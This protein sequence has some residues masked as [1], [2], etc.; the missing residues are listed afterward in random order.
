MKRIL[1][2]IFIFALCGCKTKTVTQIEVVHD[3]LTVHHSDTLR[4]V[5]VTHHTDTVREIQ[6]HFITLNEKGDTIKE[7]HHYHDIQH[8][9]IV[10]STDRYQSK[11][12]SLQSV[13]NKMKEKETVVTKKPSLWQRM[14]NFAIGA[15]VGIVACVGAWLARKL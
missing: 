6:T 8:T 13:I 15:V 5:K 9:I 7:V 14:R 10:D 2:I 12:D 4:E 3:T 11:V 1:Y